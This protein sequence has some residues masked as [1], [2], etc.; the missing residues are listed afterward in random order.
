MTEPTGDSTGSLAGDSAG[1]S[2]GDAANT[3]DGAP[4]GA[5][6]WILVGLVKRIHGTGGEMLI[7]QL[8]ESDERFA[9]GSE[10]H[11]M[12]KREQELTPVRIESSRGSDR[13]PIVRLEGI[14]SLEDAKP[15]FGASLFI[16]ATELDEPEEGSYYAFQI[17]GCEVYEGERL[18]GIVTRLAE[19]PKANPYIEIEP[20]GDEEKLLLVPFISQAIISVDVENRRI[21]LAEGFAE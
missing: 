20:D 5:P 4:T 13:G 3:T 19:T 14:A 11:L 12:R 1:G 6:E 15:L 21:E 10:L 16:R 9:A 2:A 7:L 8:T 17:E 18:V